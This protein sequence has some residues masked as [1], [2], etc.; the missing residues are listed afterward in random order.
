MLRHLAFL[1]RIVLMASEILGGVAKAT[2]PS[3]EDSAKQ[4]CGE[5]TSVRLPLLCRLDDSWL[6]FRNRHRK[7]PPS[8]F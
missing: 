8:E 4:R 6:H 2:P 7:A 5:T 3:T 1:R